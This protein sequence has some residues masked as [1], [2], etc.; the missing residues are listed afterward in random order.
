MLEEDIHYLSLGW[1]APWTGCQ[2]ITGLTPILYTD[3]C[4]YI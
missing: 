3:D 4:S 2:S 1:G